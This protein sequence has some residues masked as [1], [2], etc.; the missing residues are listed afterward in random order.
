MI[1][2]EGLTQKEEAFCR[3]LVLDGLGPSAAFRKAY[4][5]GM[6]PDAVASSAKRVLRRSR[7][8]SRIEELRGEVARGGQGLTPKQDAFCLYFLET[9]S[10]SAAYRRAYEV[11]PSA[12][13]ETVN[14]NAHALLQNTKIATRV[15]QLRAGLQRRFEVAIDRL[16]EEYARLAF[17]NIA[18]LI[19]WDFAVVTRD[20]ASGD[21][22]ATANRVT[23]KADAPRSAWAAVESVQITKTG[24]RLCMHDKAWALDGLARHL[25]LFDEA[26]RT[27]R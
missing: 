26:A 1:V 17:S 8:R 21:I 19:D 25:G 10:A 3:A 24:F 2:P 16:V 14:R 18:D 12:K 11:A 23:I 27:P 7:V 5:S 15:A 13:T 9:G 22:V 6:G 4:G 20:A